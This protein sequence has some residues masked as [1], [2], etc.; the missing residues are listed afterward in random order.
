MGELCVP[1]CRYRS[2]YEGSQASLGDMAAKQARSVAEHRQ[3]RGDLARLLK[4]YFPREFQAAERSLGGPMADTDD[5]VVVAYL[6]QLLAARHIDGGLAGL[7]AALVAAGFDITTDDVDQWAEAVRDRP[8]A[9]PQAAAP[10]AAVPA[11]PAPSPAAPATDPVTTVQPWASV[12]DPV[13]PADVPAAALDAPPP[14][15]PPDDEPLPGV[16]A[17]DELLRDLGGTGLG[18]P[19]PEAG[20]ADGLEV[21]VAHDGVPDAPWLDDLDDLF[22]D[23]GA[24][25]DEGGGEGDAPVPDVPADALSE[26]AVAEHV[27]ADVVAPADAPV[28]GPGGLDDLFGELPGDT[29]GGSALDDLFGGP[30]PSGGV[31]ADVPADVAAGG[32]DDLFGD[33][34]APG[35]HVPDAQ[36]PI[37]QV[38]GAQTAGGPGPA[39]VPDPAPGAPAGQTMQLPLK[40]EVVAP[41]R[42]RGGRRTPRARATRGD[43]LEEEG[44]SGPIEDR[45]RKALLAAVAIPRPMF[46]ADLATV[47]GSRD[48][49]EQ[50]EVEMRE[51]RT[52][53]PVRFIAGK[54]RHRK[55]GSLV[56][57]HGALR[58]AGAGAGASWW[59]D[60]LRRESYRGSR[61]YELAVLLHRVGSDVIASDFDDDAAVLRVNEERGLVGIVVVLSDDLAPGGA[62]HERLRSSL[63]AL[64][65]ERLGLVAVLVIN[66]EWE[67]R[68]CQTVE[69]LARAEGWAPNAPV[70]YST[71][72]EWADDAGSTAKLVVG[73]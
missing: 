17:L 47:A 64:V 50:W 56:I 24:G 21:A 37:A 20:P 57:P 48:Q 5:A 11:P 63:G 58:D 45:T 23:G 72:W 35:A 28:A 31:P 60:C 70:V 2:L 6:D 39:A 27:A 65:R 59:S 22:G 71:T 14:Q 33:V 67:T 52:G 55:R 53:A 16:D 29:G 36:D 41:G 73:G 30:S 19:G 25:P 32:L 43:V 44:P 9:A 8:P 66:A 69:E 13:A 62:A 34:P 7:R 3:L 18:G 68:V 38:P 61:L 51:L 40:P 42:K 54:P 49:V 12:P 46:V 4:R 26:F 1:G 10:Q 15:V